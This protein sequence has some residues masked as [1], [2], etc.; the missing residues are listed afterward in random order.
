MID[1][2]LQRLDQLEYFAADQKRRQAAM[3]RTGVVKSLGDGGAIVVELGDDENPFP[4]HGVPVNTHAGAGA[5]WRPF[6]AGQQVTL[7]SAD[8]DLAN[9]VA[10]PGGYHDK[11]PAPSSADEDVLAARG[12]VRLRT[13]AKSAS[14]IASDKGSLVVHQDGWVTSTVSGTAQFVIFDGASYWTINPEALLP[15]SA[16]PKP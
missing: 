12:K 13:T 15:A 9:A 2:I 4:T 11:N 14:A 1:E 8:G 6:K 5:D 3:I 10:I 7:I 16:P